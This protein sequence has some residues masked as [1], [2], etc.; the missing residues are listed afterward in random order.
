MGMQ[1]RRRPFC[2]FL[3]PGGL[4]AGR[5]S[6]NTMQGLNRSHGMKTRAIVIAM[7]CVCASGFADNADAK[8]IQAN[9]KASGKAF[10]ACDK[11]GGTSWPQSAENPTYGCI[12]KNGHGLVCGGGTEEQKRTCDTFRAVP[13]RLLDV[14]IPQIRAKQGEKAAAP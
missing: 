14:F 13:P 2:R 9:S 7:L 10:S 6:F 3:R 1:L 11:N 8:T 12:D 5:G 4:H